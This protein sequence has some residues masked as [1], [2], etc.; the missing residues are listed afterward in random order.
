MAGT[1]ILRSISSTEK[2]CSQWRA[3]QWRNAVQKCGGGVCR[4]EAPQGYQSRARLQ[5]GAEARD[6][7]LLLLAQLIGR[8]D[9]VVDVP[10]LLQRSTVRHERVRPK[11]SH[12]ALSRPL[13]PSRHSM[14]RLS[15]TRS[16]P[17]AR[18]ETRSWPC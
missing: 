18:D 17:A 13:K 5:L 2:T 1:L 15:T 11:A 16:G 7:V 3:V 8:A 12:A 10:L 4:E 14:P 6:E 9:L